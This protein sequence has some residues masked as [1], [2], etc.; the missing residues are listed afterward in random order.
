MLEERAR[1]AEKIDWEVPQQIINQ[2]AQAYDEDP[3]KVGRDSTH[4][5]RYSLTGV[6]DA[7]RA[8]WIGGTKM[9][10]HG[11]LLPSG[12][13][14][15]LEVLLPG[16]STGPAKGHGINQFALELGMGRGRVATQLFAMGAAVV[17][18][19]LARER[20]DLATT[21]L[22]RLAH[23][24]PDTYE[25]VFVRREASRIRRV[26]NHGALFEARHGNFFDRV[27]EAEIRVATLI[28]LQ[29]CLPPAV[30][31]RLRTFL[32]H[33]KPGCRILSYEDLE[34]VWRGVGR[35]H[36][37]PFRDIGTPLLACSWAASEGHRFYCYER[38]A[39]EGEDDEKQ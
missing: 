32:E 6:M 10:N 35:G 13:A 16:L 1:I 34:L 37:F 31:P 4:M 28:I 11:E 14:K 5:S 17:G 26:S 22:E 19:E 2:L 25:M 9:L 20:Y 29:V 30:W 15:A 33:C 24:C 36:Q 23:R 38:L 39:K 27:V 3:S 8:A 7:A 18:V 12:T 21:A